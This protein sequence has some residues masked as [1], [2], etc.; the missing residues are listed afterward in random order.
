[1]STRESAIWDA[2]L[3]SGALPKGA[4]YYDCRVGHPVPAPAGSTNWLDL[5]RH[6]T[7]RKRVD[8]ILELPRCWWLF[9]VKV[10]AGLS[11]VGQ[12]LGYELLFSAGVAEVK[13]VLVCIVC[14]YISRDVDTLCDEYGVGLYVV[15][16]QPWPLW[17]EPA[18]ADV[19]VP[20]R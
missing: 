8:A 7:S 14:D 11:A 20:V 6:A 5:A 13:P 4:L 1:M 17:H 3:R 9:E 16:W 2:F 10:R 12:A 19:F 18:L 15:S